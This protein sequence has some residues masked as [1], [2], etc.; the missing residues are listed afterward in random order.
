MC[1]KKQKQKKH[2]FVC[3]GFFRGGDVG[4]LWE[5]CLFCLLFFSRV[6]VCADVKTNTIVKFKNVLI[7]QL[8]STL[9]HF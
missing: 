9:C 4:F 3:L 2:F 7:L 6:S 5:G 8:L 1:L